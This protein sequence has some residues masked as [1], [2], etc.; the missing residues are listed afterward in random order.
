MTGMLAAPAI[1]HPALI[2]ELLAMRKANLQVPQHC[3]H[4]SSLWPLPT[5]PSA[6]WVPTDVWV[7]VSSSDKCACV[8]GARGSTTFPALLSDIAGCC[9]QH[10]IQWACRWH[11]RLMSCCEVL[12][13]AVSG[14]MTLSCRDLEAEWTASCAQARALSHSPAEP[15]PPSSPLAC[16]YCTTLPSC[17]TSIH[18]VRTLTDFCRFVLCDVSRLAAHW[19]SDAHASVLMHCKH[20]S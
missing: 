12:C 3:D 2:Q 1:A 6:P 8:C 11:T 16:R 5:L 14:L 7:S 10:D 19:C 20:C 4:P 13:L 18:Y 15:T 17:I 9:L